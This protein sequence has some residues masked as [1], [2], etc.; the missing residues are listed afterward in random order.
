MPV[1]FRYLII[2]LMLQSPL[3]TAD[4]PGD[5]DRG[6]DVALAG[7]LYSQGIYKS[8]SGVFR[9]LNGSFTNSGSEGS[10]HIEFPS[11]QENNETE[12]RRWLKETRNE[13]PV[14][15]FFK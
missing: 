1:R 5:A 2:G 10:P 15:R 7:F 9:P 4:L 6:L 3:A 14:E 8:E 13:V 11:R 12:I